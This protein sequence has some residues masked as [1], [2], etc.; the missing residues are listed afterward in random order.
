MK[1]IR[2]N[3]HL[4]EINVRLWLWEL[5]KIYNRP[6]KLGTIPDFEWE[7]LR[8]LGFDYVWLM[9]I[10][11]VSSQGR[12]TKALEPS[13]TTSYSK[14]L[15]GWSKDDIVGSPYSIYSYRINPEIGKEADL[16]K[17]LKTMHKRDLR[18][19]LDFV[20]NHLS[21]DNPWVEANSDLFVQA[22]ENIYHKNPEL[23]FNVEVNGKVLHIAHGRDPYFPSWTDTAQLNY[24]NIETRNKMKKILQN[25]AASCDGVRC[26]MAMLC[27]N[28]VHEQVWG[29]LLNKKGFFKPK[30]EFWSEV[31]KKIKEIYHDFIFIAEVYWNMEWQLQQLGFDYT[32]DK[33]LYD[34]LRFGRAEEINEH[35]K[36]LPYYQQRS[37]RFIE[38][39]D[40]ERS[41][42]AFGNKKGLAAAIIASTVPGMRMIHH[43][44][45]EGKKTRLPVQLLHTKD[46]YVQKD[47]LIFYKS[48]L[49]IVNIPVF[50]TGK[51]R[52]LEVKSAW[53][54]NNSFKNY[55]AWEWSNKVNT[56]YVI[57][58]YSEFRAQCR[59]QILDLTHQG[60]QV[61]F[62]DLLNKEMYISN[63]NEITEL[64][65]FVDLGGFESHILQ[66]IE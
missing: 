34:R 18:L 3:P 31:T 40:E 54:N 26:D 4:I 2:N 35:L 64:G 58:N 60:T 28:D 19:I 50:H 56:I 36:A 11:E 9:G 55:L 48:L 7:Q 21:F 61:K 62:K 42:K 1:A 27:L 23:F 41:Y 25:I 53:V 33:T 65:L 52:L 57:T 14:A 13:L 37:L 15:P 32:Y 5:S 30:V 20:P 66:I 38:N 24:F 59:V 49:D 16:K 12:K 46:D 44:Q 39:H 63:C 17:V 45:M 10:W 51:W 43:G 8:K 47:I 29:W 22:D 6:I